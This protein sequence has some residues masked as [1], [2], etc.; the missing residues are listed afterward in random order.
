MYNVASALVGQ[1]D[2]DLTLLSGL[3]VK[4][5]RESLEKSGKGSKLK[6]S[7]AKYLIAGA[8]ALL[9]ASEYESSVSNQPRSEG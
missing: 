4:L 2:S 6:S 1:V 9:E 7:A 5:Q 3:I 8:K